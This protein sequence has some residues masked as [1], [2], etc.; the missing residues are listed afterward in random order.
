MFYFYTLHRLY[1][2]PAFLQHMWN[3]AV[4]KKPKTFFSFPYVVTPSDSGIIPGMASG[5]RRWKA[6]PRLILIKLQSK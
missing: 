6:L 4:K 1:H 2:F 5:C 3:T